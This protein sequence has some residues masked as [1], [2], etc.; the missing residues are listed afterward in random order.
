MFAARPSGLRFGVRPA[1]CW[2]RTTVR[3][4]AP[5]AA[6]FRERFLL[7]DAEE[8]LNTD[9]E[10]AERCASAVAA[11]TTPRVST[12]AR[13]EPV[14]GCDLP[15]VPPQPSA[16]HLDRRLPTSTTAP[17]SCSARRLRGAVQ[18]P[19]VLSDRGC[20]RRIGRGAGGVRAGGHQ[21]VQG[22]MRHQP[23][24][25]D[26]RARRDR[27][28]RR[29]CAVS[30]SDRPLSRRLDELR[31]VARRWPCRQLRPSRLHHPRLS[32]DTPYRP[33]RR[34]RRCGCGARS[35]SSS[36]RAKAPSGDWVQTVDG[37]RGMGCQAAA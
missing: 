3:R 23:A 28:R 20:G 22:G 12:L 24:G 37:P 4:T 8:W 1:G 29:C 31:Q 34:S 11:S 7:R 21:I 27:M 9:V 19:V 36:M 17:R 18:R 25:V 32:S 15:R 35:S 5:G 33:A 16:A 2:R 10:P 6:D 26:Q 30:P 14:R 13:Q